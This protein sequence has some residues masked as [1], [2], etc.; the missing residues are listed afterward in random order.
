M[1]TKKTKA[2]LW[3]VAVFSLLTLASGQARR[4][5]K[6][7]GIGGAAECIVGGNPDGGGTVGGPQSPTKTVARGGTIGRSAR[8]GG[9]IG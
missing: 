9:T 4:V 6:G 5:T 7:G 8:E 3:T 2:M 1:R